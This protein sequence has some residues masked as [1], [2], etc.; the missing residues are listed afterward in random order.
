MEYHGHVEKGRVIL[1][2]PT[3]LPDGTEVR[4]HPVKQP[5]R[6]QSPAGRRTGNSARKPTTVSRRLLRYAGCIDDLPS[7]AARNLDHYL[8]GHPKR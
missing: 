6:R 4:V 8:Y 3:A 7:D 5:D 1:N 2:D